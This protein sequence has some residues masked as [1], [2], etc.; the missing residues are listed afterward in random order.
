MRWAASEY[1]CTLQPHDGGDLLGFLIGDFST[2]F[3]LNC[4]DQFNEVKRIGFEVFA[5][6]RIDADF[7]RLATP[8]SFDNDISARSKVDA[9][10]APQ[11]SVG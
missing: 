1:R 10:M 8:S 2:E 11:L 7:T 6:T 4:H 3:F 5:E 9:I